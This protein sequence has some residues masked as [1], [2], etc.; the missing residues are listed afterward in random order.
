VLSVVS[1]STI[2]VRSHEGKRLSLYRSGIGK[3][4]LAWHPAPVRK[5]IIAQLV[6]ETAPPTT[7]TDPLQLSDELERIRQRGW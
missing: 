3:C 4:L 6:W 1:S 2:S 5:A 7:I